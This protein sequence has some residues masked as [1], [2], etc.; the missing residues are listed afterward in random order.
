MTDSPLARS[1]IGATVATLRLHGVVFTYMGAAT[2]VTYPEGIPSGLR[3]GM[4]GRR[5][6]LVAYLRYEA[7]AMDPRPD[8]T[9][10]HALWERLLSSAMALDGGS[11]D[12]VAQAL[13]GLRC[14]GA[15]IR[16]ERG[17]WVIRR[18][19]LPAPEY[20]DLRRRWLFPYRKRVATLLDKLGGDIM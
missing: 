3:H 18:G 16:R 4:A 8:L 15:V 14:L 11:P 19:E 7:L 6:E 12:G 2:E 1:D 13:N 17:A 10:D 5:V 20:E 9:E